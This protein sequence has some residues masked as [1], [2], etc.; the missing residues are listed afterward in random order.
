MDN[1][2]PEDYVSY[3]AHFKVVICKPCKQC[4]R[5]GG[6][7]RHF[8]QH[9]NDIAS[10]IRKAI[11]AYCHT[12]ELVTPDAVRIPTNGR[13][14]P[15]LRIQQGLKCSEPGCGYLCPALA[16]AQTH[17][18]THGWLLRDP[19]MWSEVYIQVISFTVADRSPF[20]LVTKPFIS[21]STPICRIHNPRS[22]AAKISFQHF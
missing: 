13:P 15:E 14:V 1:A 3:N 19:P 6:A 22:R 7:Y 2:E 8:M 21:K 9:K 20:F 10:P 12:L 16:T 18:R 5:P 4:I 17:A 11:R